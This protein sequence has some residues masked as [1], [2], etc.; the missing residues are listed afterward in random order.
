MMT[1]A[2]SRLWRYFSIAMLIAVTWLQGFPAHSQPPSQAHAP[3]KLVA[4]AA[5]GSELIQFD[6][7]AESAALVRRSSVTIPGAIQY[8]W[9]HPSRRSLYVAWSNGEGGQNGV[10][11]LSIDP[12]SGT[13]QPL[14]S[15]VYISSRP[16]HI[17]TDIP[18]AHVLVAYNNP[19]GVT[20]HQIATDGSIGS[21]VDEPQGLDTGIYAHQVRVDP[22][23]RMVIVVTR[24]NGP[25]GGKPEDPGALKIFHYGDGLL[26]N[27]VSIA[28]GKGIDFQPR[29]LDF[30]PAKPW[31]FV[32]LE[33][34]CKLQ[35]YEKLQG[36]TLG[37][38]P[39]FTKGSLEKTSDFGPAQ[40]AGAIHVHPNG[41]FVYQANRSSNTTDFDGQQVF[42]G[43]EN[44]IAVF[45]IN[46]DTGEPTL[47]QNMD[48]HG[49]QPRTFSLDPS[50]RILVVGNQMALN[51][52]SGEGVR[53]V[54]ANL[55]VY[56]IRKDG[57][58][59]FV[60]END[61]E[62]GRGRTLMWMG[63]VALP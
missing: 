9:P 37:A 60:R 44:N 17:T 39:M 50:G 5:V 19:S 23:N 40:L 14:G 53:V 28:P 35:V 3:G 55:S 32:S 27:R 25:S 59:D 31:I 12:V 38:A 45:A 51:V 11:A 21:Q 29:H 20:V 33:R 48:T 2:L 8:A 1:V 46:P 22:T 7:N 26:A 34:Q 6:L 56:K 13:L 54:P 30:H 63:I 61:V 42:A 18:G 24:G 10:S 16:I 41:K 36:D 15:P 47:I 52:R 49:F 62:S 4:Y 43:G 58:L 57:K